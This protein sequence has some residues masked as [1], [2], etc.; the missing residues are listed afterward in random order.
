MCVQQQSTVLSY[1]GVFLFLEVG[2]SITSVRD[3]HCGNVHTKASHFQQ[4]NV[5][6]GAFVHGVA[7]VHARD[8]A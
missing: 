6:G 8:R 1:V 4:C 5:H 2:V 7:F 3:V